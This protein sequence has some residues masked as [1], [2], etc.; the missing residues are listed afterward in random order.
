MG[1]E[2]VDGRFRITGIVGRGNMGEVH[3]AEDLRAAQ[4]TPYREVALKTVLRGRTG[5]AVDAS[6]TRAHA[7]TDPLPGC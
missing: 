3:R 4:D 1:L 7:T 5:I 2:T 6:G